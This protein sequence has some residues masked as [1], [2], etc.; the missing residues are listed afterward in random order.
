QH[1]S[2]DTI[3]ALNQKKNNTC[4]TVKQCGSIK[5]ARDMGAGNSI[6]LPSK[7][8]EESKHIVKNLPTSEDQENLHPSTIKDNIYESIEKRALMADNSNVNLEKVQIF[9]DSKGKLAVTDVCPTVDAIR[10]LFEQLVD[11]ML[12]AKPSTSDD[13]PSSQQRRVAKHV[14]SVVLLH[15]YYHRKQHLKLAFMAFKEFCKL[16]VDLSPTLLTYMKFT[17]KPDQTNL[18]DMEQQLSITKKR[19]ISRG[20]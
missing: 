4:G 11:P 7:N 8:K 17:Q 15:N 10:A 19:L 2:N 20:E 16:A 3:E 9:T 5:E 1:H 13:P 12:Q 6:V 18:V 14:H